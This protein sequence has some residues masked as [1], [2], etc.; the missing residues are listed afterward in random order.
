M[1]ITT[2]NVCVQEALSL[3]SQPTRESSTFDCMM[4]AVV[5]SGL[6]QRLGYLL[7]LPSYQR[8]SPL[9]CGP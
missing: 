1:N 7:S 4:F 8:A 3:Y 6:E 5:A 9:K 2:L